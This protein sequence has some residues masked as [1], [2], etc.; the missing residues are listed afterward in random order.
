M[1]SLIT[2]TSHKTRYKLISSNKVVFPVTLLRHAAFAKVTV[3]F[4]LPEYARGRT[5]T[6]MHAD[7]NK[8]IRLLGCTE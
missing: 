7:N 8:H 4:F 1:P 2:G 6:H 5:H 3:T